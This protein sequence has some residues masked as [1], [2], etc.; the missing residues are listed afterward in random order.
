MAVKSRTVLR[1]SGEPDGEL[2]HYRECGL[3]NVYL[4]NGWRWEETPVGR[5]LHIRD[6]RALFAALARHIVDRPHQPSGQELR[7]LRVFLELSQAALGQL[8]GLSDQQVAR[9]EKEQSRIEPA[10]LRLLALLVR[11]RLGEKIEIESELKSAALGNARVPR[12]R[13]AHRVVA[14]RRSGWRTREAA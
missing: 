9:W 12:N 6:D 3:D 7:Y 11:E 1:R 2:L 13:R 14:F 8:L 5:F 4:S 10:V